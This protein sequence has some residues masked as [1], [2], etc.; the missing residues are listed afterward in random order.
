[1]ATHE[2][3]LESLKVDYTTALA[4]GDYSVMI[5]FAQRIIIT[6]GQAIRSDPSNRSL[7]EDLD[8]WEKTVM[9]LLAIQTKTGHNG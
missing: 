6:L 5:S 3:E 9:V 8:N 4:Y 7:R 1:M 2:R